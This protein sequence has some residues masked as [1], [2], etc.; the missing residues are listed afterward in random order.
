MKFIVAIVALVCVSCAGPKA[1]EPS[2]GEQQVAEMME[3]AEE[4]PV[5]APAEEA[6]VEEEAAEEK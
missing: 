2:V 3:A 1:E 4:A 6:V 5:E